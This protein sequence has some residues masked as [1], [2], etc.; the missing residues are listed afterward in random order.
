MI[1]DFETCS[2]SR[3]PESLSLIKNNTLISTHLSESITLSYIPT[4]NTKMC[5][6]L[7]S[8]PLLVGL[9]NTLFPLFHDLCLCPWWW[10]ETFYLLVATGNASVWYRGS[11]NR[12]CFVIEVHRIDTPWGS[13]C[14]CLNLPLFKQKAGW[15]KISSG[16]SSY[17]NENS[18]LFN[19][20]SNPAIHFFPLLNEEFALNFG[21]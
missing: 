13:H 14:R 17:K 21:R 3:F 15:V 5:S 4:W 20:D 11:S 12:P 2:E 18:E 19:Q 1:F 16:N 9:D 8:S 10:Y 7:G 6:D